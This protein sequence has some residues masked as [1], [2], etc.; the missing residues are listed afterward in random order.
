MSRHWGV[1]PVFAYEWLTNSRRPQFYAGR[2]LFVVV[3]LLG[4][5]SV[6]GSQIAGRASLSI[7]ETAEVGR[8]F[9]VAI[10]ATQLTLVLLAAPAATASAIC[11][12]K[13][14]G[15]LMQLLMTD[16]SDVEIVLGKLAARLVP[17]LGL[18]TTALPVLALGTLLG[19]IDPVALT[20]A[21][22]VTVSMA[23]LGCTLAFTLSIWGTKP[24]EVL[25]ATFAVFTVWLLA[26][27]IWE[28]L[29]AVRGFPPLPRWGIVANPY[30][31][32][33]EP[34]A[35]R[36]NVDALDYAG[37][38]LGALTVSTTLVL[39]SI[40]RLRS[41]VV[42]QADQVMER[43]ATRQF[44]GLLPDTGP[45]LDKHP[46]LWYEW[47]RKR[48]T[49]WIRKLIAFYTV[50]AIGFT[51]LA[52]EDCFHQ[53][54]RA[55]GWL[56]G[57]VTAFQVVMGIPLLLVSATMA[58][59]E[60]RARGSLDILLTTPLSSKGIVL[61]KWWSVFRLTPQLILLPTLIAVLLAWKY[62]GWL[63]V[64][65]YV[66]FLISACA[67]WT[68]V[69]L[70]LS[71]WIARVG[72]AVST[73]VVLFATSSLGW[74]VMSLTILSQHR[75]L[76]IGF[77]IIS[78][79]YGSFYLI[80][81]LGESPFSELLFYTTFWTVMQSVLSVGLLFVTLATFDRRLGRISDRARPVRHAP[82][83]PARALRQ[84]ESP[85]VPD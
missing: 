43:T 46:T 45:P 62:G 19:G 17:V 58:M 49:P 13:S 71:T 18:V 10:V 31:L 44:F 70:L 27:P 23:I 39:L 36:G 11:Q 80:V 22:A 76:D 9:F 64:G 37:F 29:S 75:P 24:H 61:A 82:L 54:T 6:W 21:F 42:A 26:A 2:V 63:I 81:A 33:F 14:R 12:D 35:R 16:V 67:L 60:E 40:V 8:S 34:Y 68:S 25:L 30:F 1:G 4:L 48:P 41:V 53:G 7:G 66:L 55:P 15:N 56:Q 20:G 5:T 32:A 83:E 79:F 74:P 57:Y 28:F 77:A 3:L 72:R 84:L 78:P 47:H 59:V 51:A 50:M 73:A 52:I 38:V 69:G 65:L 85:S